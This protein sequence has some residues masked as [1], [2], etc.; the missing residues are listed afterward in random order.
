M[1][2]KK[3]VPLVEEILGKWK[4]VIG[5]DYQAY[6][7][8]VYRVIH[9]CMTLHA[10]NEE[11]Q[12]KI[13]I[14]GCFHD[15]GIW[16][17]DTIDYLAPSILLAK[18]YLEQ[19]NLAHWSDEIELM[20]DM[21]HKI[22]KYDDDTYPLV[23]WFRRADLVDVSLGKVK[24][25]LPEDYIENVRAVFPNSGFHMRLL[26]LAASWFLKHPFNPAPMMKW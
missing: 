10:C 23:E 1:E 25:G 16:T 18:E 22:R 8:H 12:E 7:N 9:F 11:D 15:L 17:D 14:A 3:N 13:I 6:K 26:Q 20:I 19:R 5:N 21:H 2:I 4:E 24:M